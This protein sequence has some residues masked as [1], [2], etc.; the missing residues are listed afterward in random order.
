MAERDYMFQ[1][2]SLMYRD[3]WFQLVRPL[4]FTSTL[5]PAIAGTALAA[6]NGPIRYD[7]FISVL[8]VGLLV[9]CSVNMLNDY[10]DFQKGQDQEKWV[11]TKGPTPDRRPR[12]RKVPVVASILLL[13]AI[14][15]GLWVGMESDI[16]KD[17]N[18][19]RTIAMRLNRNRA[20]KVLFCILALAYLILLLL[21]I[22]RIITPLALATFMASSSL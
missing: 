18:I 17:Q 20:A 14:M 13:L 7:L 22:Y 15:I 3:S 16:Q 21:I 4:T 12:Y 1:K 8:L 5:S 6:A 9:Q 10:Y 2:E 11:L 19:R